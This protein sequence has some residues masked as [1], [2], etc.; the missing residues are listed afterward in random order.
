MRRV[1]YLFSRTHSWSFFQALEGKPLK[2]VEESAELRAHAAKLLAGL[3]FSDVFASHTTP[4]RPSEFL[5]PHIYRLEPF[6]DFLSQC[7][8][9]FVR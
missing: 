9:I 3:H 4:L 7:R 8:E 6:E 2:L 5:Q 1:V